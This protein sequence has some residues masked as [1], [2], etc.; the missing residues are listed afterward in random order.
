MVSTHVVDGWQELVDGARTDAQAGH[1]EGLGHDAERDRLVVQVAHRRELVVA[2]ALA[3]C[4]GWLRVAEEAIDLVGEDKDVV[5]TRELDEPALRG[6]VHA[7]AGR[8]VGTVDHDPSHL[9]ASHH[10]HPVSERV[11]GKG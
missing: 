3:G 10:Q 11:S 9:P 2:L 5:L 4:C 1:A 6:A 7:V 8:V